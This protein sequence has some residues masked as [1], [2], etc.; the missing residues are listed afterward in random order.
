[1]RRL[2]FPSVFVFVLLAAV[3]CSVRAQSQEREWPALERQL[4]A[5]RVTAGS[6]LERLIEAN[7]DFGRLRPEEAQD[8]LPVPL[9]LRVIWRKAHPETVYDAADPTGGYPLALK[10][11]HEWMVEHQ[12]LTPPAPEPDRSPLQKKAAV[13]ANVRMS[14]EQGDA[15]SESDIRINYLDPQK[16]ISASNNLG[17]SGRQAQ[18]YSTDGGHTWGQTTLP[19][20]SPDAFH[21]D[22]TVEWTSDGLAWSITIGIDDQ[23]TALRL[24]AYRSADG[25]ATWFFDST[26]SGGQTATDKQ[27]IWVDHSAAS[28][29][30]DTLYVIWHNDAPV[31]VNHRR[32]GELW[33]RPLKVSRTETR[34]TGIGGD[35]KTNRAGH[36]FAFWPDTGSR[37]IYFVKST[38][39]GQ[40]FSAPAAI[41]STFDS[42][43]IGLPAQNSRRAL[44]YV[45]AGAFSGGGKN[46]A[47]A[48][49]TDLTGAKGCRAAGNE[50]GGNANSACKT[51]IWFARST[52]GGGT[53]SAPRMLNNAAAKTD[54]FNQALVVDEATGT[55]AVVYYDT[56]GDASRRKTNLWYQSS[57]DDGATWS[58]PL[59]V[60]SAQSD[61]TNIGAEQGNQYGDY[62]S[63]SGYAGLFLPSWTDR[64]T[65]SHEEIWTAP[66]RESAGVCSPPI[67]P[68]TLAATR[69]AGGHVQLAWDAV[70]EVAE[71]RIYRAE[72]RADAVDAGDPAEPAWV[73]VARVPAPA[74]SWIDPDAR[75]GAAYDYRVKAATAASCES[76]DFA[77]ASVP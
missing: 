43:D 75:R 34:G 47:Y 62:N 35:V 9:W 53:W 26:L 72:A 77:E 58:A 15:R 27:M 63:L 64:R 38:N 11:V 5:D 73:Q 1:M 32:P 54:Q 66:V 49:W 24:R 22:P 21:T 46:L 67:A 60:S 36:V 59:K 23:G 52:N 45:S 8:G 42:F 30:R 44:I 29:Y 17:G 48:A 28:P 20:V 40:T 18:F 3:P 6:A 10:E 69:G 51:R 61:E 4:A 39:G 33:A 50:P 12:D 71:Y 7:Q 25:G 55:V 13:S 74:K 70:P 65:R 76:S 31:Y 14:G 19:L 57:S 37:K 2:S 68:L 56:V 16:V 41:A